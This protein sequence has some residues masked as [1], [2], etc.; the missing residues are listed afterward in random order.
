MIES[1]KMMTSGQVAR[2]IGVSITTI[3]N[4]EERGA[5]K[6]D[7][8]LPSGRRLYSEKTVEDFIKSLDN[9]DY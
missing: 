3:K 4:W 8:K 6:P 7:R 9:I 5:L 1:E 2:T